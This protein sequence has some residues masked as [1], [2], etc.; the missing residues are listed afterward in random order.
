[1]KPVVCEAVVIGSG[2]GGAVSAALL[3]EAGR[4]VVLLEE[5]S[6][7]TQDSC[8]PFSL[9][10]ME[11][12]YRN[13]GLTS[14]MGAPKVT[15]VEGCTVGGGSEIN[16][17]LYHRIPDEVLE[18]WRKDYGVDGLSTADLLPLFERNER[19]LSTV[20]PPDP[21]P[22]GSRKL[23]EG[24]ERL[25][26]AS[27]EVP[28]LATFGAEGW[29]RQSMTETFLPRFVKA[30]GRLLPETLVLRVRRNGSGWIVEA[31]KKSGERLHVRAEKVFVAAGAI[32]T[33]VL[34]RRSGITENV[35]DSLRCHPTL[36][37]LAEFPE[38]VNDVASPLGT[39]QVKEFSPASSFGCSVSFPP[40]VA[41]GSTSDPSETARVAGSWRKMSLFYSMTVSEARGKIRPIPGLRDPWVS[42][43]MADSEVRNL[44]QGGSALV[45]L[46]FE[47]GAA[48]VS[49]AIDGFA[50][51]ERASFSPSRPA[52]GLLPRGRAQIMTIHLFSSCPM[53]ENRSLCA[54]DSYGRVHGHSG[55]HVVDA[56]VL[57]TAPGV[58]PQGTIMALSRRNTLA[59]LDAWRR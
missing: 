24:A 33:P 47:A 3:A 27:Q 34:L 54:T 2:P 48:R 56:S 35:G 14:M 4:D 23:L 39:R 58:N 44:V 43:R 9:G 32:H 31:A 17:G 49:P 28:R 26:W 30:G 38:D 36:K 51:I 20:I 1:V 37:M 6:S 12:K 59:A 13:G 50:P 55:L 52:I 46:L 10:E 53:G 16:A 45:R 8:L 57:C 22:P 21:K 5:G 7:R 29:R 42:Y 11:Q 40:F 15:Y 18:T 25:G 19:E 41:L